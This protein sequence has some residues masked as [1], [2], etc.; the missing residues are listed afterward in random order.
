MKTIEAP[1]IIHAK[2]LTL[3]EWVLII[4]QRVQADAPPS[5]GQ[6]TMRGNLIIIGCRLNTITEKMVVADEPISTK[7]NR[8]WLIWKLPYGHQTNEGPLLSPSNPLSWPGDSGE[9]LE[10]CDPGVV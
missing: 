7:I 6:E 1:T 10:V 9:P 4:P 5:T 3:R 8:S 2:E